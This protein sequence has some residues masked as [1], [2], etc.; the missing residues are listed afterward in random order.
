MS[1][2]TAI[3]WLTARLDVSIARFLQQSAAV[4]LS[5]LFGHNGQAQT[6]PGFGRSGLL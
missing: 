4:R 1:L 6:G 5:R 2:S 3:S